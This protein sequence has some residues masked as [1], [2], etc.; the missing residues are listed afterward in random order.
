MVEGSCGVR[1]WIFE[2]KDDEHQECACDDFAEEL[3]GFCN[4]TLRVCAEYCGGGVGS[5][6]HGAQIVALEVINGGD[7]IGVYDAR[8]NEAAEDL[9][10][11]VNGEA[12][13]GELPKETV[14]EGYSWIE[15]CA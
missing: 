4:E 2:S 10:D 11:E 15:V 6:W 3:A 13:P 8:A 9:G 7:V 1:T 12:P 14:A 5:W